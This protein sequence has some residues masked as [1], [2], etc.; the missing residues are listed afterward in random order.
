MTD[1]RKIWKVLAYAGW[2]VLGTGILVLLVAAVQTRS[3]KP[4]SGMEIVINGN[5]EHLYLEKREVA[6]ILRSANLGDLKGKSMKDLDLKK[7]EDAL[8]LDPWINNAEL[9]FDNDRVLQI[10]VEESRPLARIFTQKGNSFYIDSTMKRLPLNEHYSPRLPVF[11]GFPSERS[12]WKGKDSILMSDI[13]RLAQFIVHDSFWMAQVD[14]VDINSRSE[15]ELIPKVG[16]HVVLFGDGQDVKSKFNRLMLF[17]DQVLS[18]TGWNSYGLVNVQYSGQVVATRK[19][20]RSVLADTTQAREWMRQLMQK[21]QR[22][23][24]PE[25]DNNKSTGRASSS[26]NSSSSI[27][28][29]GSLEHVPDPSKTKADSSRNKLPKAVMPPPKKVGVAPLQKLAYLNPVSEIKHVNIAHQQIKIDN[30]KIEY[31]A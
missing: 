26:E 29:P 15:F 6:A 31:H 1:R 20:K 12:G 11:T 22:M 24:M 30:Q 27:T 18:R 10:Q 25:N 14:Q 28:T 17:Y 16:D 19:D 8:E 3:T 2:G 13:A 9:F 7:M 21:S 4:C 23:N 5:Q